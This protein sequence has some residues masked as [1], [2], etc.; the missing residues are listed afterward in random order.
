MANFSPPYDPSGRGEAAYTTNGGP[1]TGGTV[2]ANSWNTCIMGSPVVSGANVLANCVGYAQ[3]RMLTI[4]R[5]ITGYNPAQTLTHPFVTL[6]TDPV[7]GA[8]GW[9]PRA[10]AAGL[11][12]QAEPRAGSVLVSDTHVAV[13]E[14]F[15]STTNQWMISES[16]Y[17]GPA[18]SFSP[19]I[20]KSGSK[21]YTNFA[22]PRPQEIYGFILIPNVQPGPEPPGPDPPGPG[23]KFPE[24]NFIYYLKNW[25][26]EIYF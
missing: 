20:Y 9:I 7:A 3:G 21:W 1:S 25:N 12:V 5:E 13:V 22:Y 2:T 23:P 11:T 17:G 18:Y 8:D 6:N 19:S 14:S 24:G 26:N 4:Y 16:G 15:D 10:Q